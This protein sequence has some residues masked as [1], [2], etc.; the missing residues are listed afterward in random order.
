MSNSSCLAGFP[1]PLQQLLNKIIV[2]CHADCSGEIEVS[3]AI[4]QE[5][6]QFLQQFS[7]AIKHELQSNAGSGLSTCLESRGRD[8]L[9]RLCGDINRHFE[10]R[11]RITFISEDT[12][13]Q[14]AAAAARGISESFARLVEL[15]STGERCA[16]NDAPLTIDLM[17]TEEDAIFSMRLAILDNTSRHVVAS[18]EPTGH[19]WNI[20]VDGERQDRNSIGPNDNCAICLCAVF[21]EQND[22]SI[23]ID[24]REMK[25][26][27]KHTLHTQ[28]ARAYF[29]NSHKERCPICRHDFSNVFCMDIALS[30][31]H[32]EPNEEER[33]PLQWMK[34][35]NMRLA[36]LNMLAQLSKETPLGRSTASAL[37]WSSLD[38]SPSIANAALSSERLS[39]AFEA[40][41]DA[42]VIF[43]RDVLKTLKTADADATR[44]HMARVIAQISEIARGRVA[45]LEAG[46]C[47]AIVQALSVAKNEDTIGSVTLAI[48]RLVD[49]DDCR[50]R[51]FRQFSEH[52]VCSHLAA[53]LV[54]VCS[55]EV[56]L[57]I[58][59]CITLQLHLL[60]FAATR[61]GWQFPIA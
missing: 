46:G 22:G 53:A 52:N 4:T 10:I 48:E 40:V 51:C 32:D 36:A 35:P 54:I 15:L 57:A 44:Y 2:L 41:P 6:H 16:G 20:S 18:S 3:N 26:P 59:N 38:T 14:R 49:N 27:G 25:C 8:L 60:L 30:L 55:D 21:E 58:S 43:I 37:L 24:A 34:S 33:R 13:T 9:V 12:E 11:P 5:L 45:V 17:D 56:R 42:R 19:L 31:E 39:A 47:G 28:C 7:A 50:I 23:H 1:E 61:C 29:I